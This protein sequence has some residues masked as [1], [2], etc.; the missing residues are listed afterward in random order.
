MA[1]TLLQP[2]THLQR[3]FTALGILAMS[4]LDAHFTLRVLDL[5]AREANPVMAHLIEM[6]DV[7]FL[8]GK[9]AL[10]AGGV[11]LLLLA[12]DRPSRGPTPLTILRICFFGYAAL[13]VWHLVLYGR[14]S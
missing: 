13:M 11:A 4:L 1:T 3:R 5:G 6:G 8:S 14:L 9:L 10:T 2:I 7:W 12:G